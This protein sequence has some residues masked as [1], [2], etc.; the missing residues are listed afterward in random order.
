MKF[1]FCETLPV[2]LRSIH[3][4]QLFSCKI[5]TQPQFPSANGGLA[6]PP[7]ANDLDVGDVTV[8][9]GREYVIVKQL[10]QGSFG[11]AWLV[12][13]NQGTPEKEY[14]LNSRINS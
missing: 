11:K 13:T 8:V 3:G 7:S 14:V 1:R 4:V 10:G 2:Q 6:P 9:G 12:R 5:V